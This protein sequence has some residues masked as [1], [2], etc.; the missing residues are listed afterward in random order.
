MIR[1]HA[2]AFL[3]VLAAGLGAAAEGMTEPGQVRL[4]IVDSYHREYLWSL[5]TN[6][7]ACAALRQFGYLDTEE[8][9][10]ACVAGDDVENPHAVVKRL[11][12]D[13]KRR[14][15]KGEMA[16]AAVRVTE[17]ARAFEP[18]LI[19]LGDDNAANYIGNQFL[20]AEIPVVFWGVNNTPV[21]Y[22][23]VDDA[24]H[25]GHN[26]T[27]VYQSGYYAESLEF[28]HTIAPNAKTFAIL[29]DD[30][31][32]GRSHLKAIEFLAREGALPL[33][34]VETVATHEF[35]EWQAKALELQERVDAFYV[36][37]YSALKDAEGRHVPAEVVAEWY[38]AHIRIPEATNMAQ[39]I[40]QGI[41]CGANDSGYNQGFEAVAIA[42]DL[43][44]QGL[45]PSEYPTRAPSRGKLMVNTRRAA[46]LGVALTPG[47]G[48]EESVDDVLGAQD[49]QA[50]HR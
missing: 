31:E 38:L 45:K 49:S 28:L 41:L 4:L 30:T 14:S 6:A 27:G 25:P 35:A 24:D 2:P 26:V 32:T 1:R 23:L 37:Q 29:S 20:D 48:I 15:G 21:K 8:Q 34:L 46:M 42:H 18:D 17:Q 13:T 16:E 9:E 36:A 43:L 22:G 12:M 50:P 5:E 40:R 3:A 19:L 39:F 33:E 10:R 7:G 11:W 47:M 44:A